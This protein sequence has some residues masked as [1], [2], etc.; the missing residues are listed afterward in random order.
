MPNSLPL[1]PGIQPSQ[2]TIKPPSSTFF[3]STTLATSPSCQPTKTRFSQPVASIRLVARCNS[4]CLY[5]R[6]VLALFFFSS[7]TSKSVNHESASVTA[8]SEWSA[9]STSYGYDGSFVESMAVIFS[10]T[11]PMLLYTFNVT[12]ST[13]IPA[14]TSVVPATYCPLDEFT[15]P[16]ECLLYWLKLHEPPPLFKRRHTERCSEDLHANLPSAGMHP[17]GIFLVPLSNPSYLEFSAWPLHLVF[18]LL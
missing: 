8:R 10:V 5:R 6:L 13:G 17:W 4:A 16:D 14:G 9:V 15:M 11:K 1:K 2:T 7:P 12:L 18:F 3:S